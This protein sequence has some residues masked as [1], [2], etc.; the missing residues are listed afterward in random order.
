MPIKYNKNFFSI[1]ISSN[2][3]FIKKSIIINKIFNNEIEGPSTIDNGKT[4]IKI[5]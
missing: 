1:F 2:L 5:K 4:E 3:K